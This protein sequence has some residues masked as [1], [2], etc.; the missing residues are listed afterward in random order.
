MTAA[1]FKPHIFCVGLRLVTAGEIHVQTL[2]PLG[3]VSMIHEARFI[4]IGSGI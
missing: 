4:E 1:K 2:R 3:S